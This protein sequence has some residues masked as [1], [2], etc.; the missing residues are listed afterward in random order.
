MKNTKLRTHKA[1][2]FMT[3]CH[4]GINPPHMGLDSTQRQA[5]ER[6]NYQK[7]ER[8]R[9]SLTEPVVMGKQEAGQLE[10]TST[11]LMWGA[12]GIFSDI[13]WVGSRGQR[14]GCWQPLDDPSLTTLGRFLGKVVSLGSHCQMRFLYILSLST[15]TSEARSPGMNTVFLPWM[16]NQC[17]KK[18]S[19]DLEQWEWSYWNHMYMLGLHDK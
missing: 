11:G 9:S 7:W 19:A 3:F 8:L 2:L 6:E 15:N 10:T 18:Y 16:W 13:T 12:R 5:G 14:Q 1:C 17:A 4:M